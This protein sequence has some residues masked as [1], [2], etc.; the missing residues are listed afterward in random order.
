MRVSVG[1]LGVFNNL[2]H[3]DVADPY[4]CLPPHGHHAQVVPPLALGVHMCRGVKVDAVVSPFLCILSFSLAVFLHLPG[5]MTVGSHCHCR[6]S[7][8]A[9][10][11]SSDS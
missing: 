7:S 4:R 2:E 10:T 1:F 9:T 8:I 5:T 6:K 3:L 11:L